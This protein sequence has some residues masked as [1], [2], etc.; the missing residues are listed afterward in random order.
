MS[1]TWVVLT[2]EHRL[3]AGLAIAA[4]R[5]G[6]VGLL[7]LGLSAPLDRRRAELDRLRRHAREGGAWGVRWNVWDAPGRMPEALQ[8][9]ADGKVPVL[10]LA[11]LSG[12]PARVAEAVRQARR[13]ADRVYVEAYDPDQAR[14]ARDARPDTVVLVGQEAGGRAGA[15][16]TF[17]FVQAVGERLGLPYLV[18][19]ATGPD[20]AAALRLGGAEGVVL[21]EETWLAREAPFDARERRRLEALDGTET[22]LLAEEGAAVRLFRH[23]DRDAV[24]AL[25]VAE[26]GGLEAVRAV[27]ARWRERPP[28]SGGPVPMGQGVAFAARLAKTAGTLGRILERYRAEV[29]HHLDRAPAQRAL[30]PDATLARVH[31][32]R[33]PVVQGPMTRVSDVPAFARAVAEHG[34]LPFFALAL[35]R[36][37]AVRRML[38]GARSQLGASPWGVGILGFVPPQLREEQL[39]VVRE[40]RPRFAIVAGGRPAQ[41]AAL[42]AEGI[43]TYLHVPSPGLL[44]AFLVEGARR[45]VLEGRECGGHVGP[46]SSFVLWQSA[47][48]RLCD[49]GVDLATVRVLFAGGIHDA[50]SAG[51]VQTLAAGLVERGV[52]IGV[53]LGTA[54]L[55]TPEAVATG[56]IS[57]AFQEEAIA[58]R[59]TTLLRSGLGH[60]S[61]CADTAFAEEFRS[62]RRSLLAAGRSA[63]DVRVDLEILNVGRLRVAS[64]GLRRRGRADAEA[65]DLASR[66]ERLEGELERVDSSEQR[67]EGMFMLGD[68]ATLRDGRQSMAALHDAVSRGAVEWTHRHA[69]PLAV[70]ARRRSGGERIAIVGMACCFPGAPDLASFWACV[71]RGADAVRDVPES[72]WS[73]SLFYDPDRRAP[74]RLYARRGAFLE[75][76][77]FDPLRYGIPPATVTHLEPVQLL[78]LETARRAL[79]DAGFDRHPFPRERTSVIFGSSG[80]H[81]LG[82]SYVFRTMVE[83]LL[84]R[85]SSLGDDARRRAVESVRAALPPWTEDVFPGVLPNLIAGRIANRLDLMGANYVVDA[86]CSSS[87][88]ALHAAVGQLRSR[89]ADVVVVGAA[90]GSNNAFTFM[91]FAKTQAL[92]PGDVPRPFDAGADGIVLGEGVGAVVLKRLEDAERD[93]DDV[94][95]VIRGIGTSSDG[96]N[97]SLT[98][99]HPAGQVLALRRA[100]EDAGVDPATVELIEA[101]ATGTAVGDAAEIE[102][103]QAVLGPGRPT[104]AIGSVKSQIGHAKTAAGLAGLVKTALALSH[105][106]LPPTLHV[107]RP[108]PRLLEAGSRVYANTERR[109]WI[110]DV[111]HP[112]RRAGVSA[113]GFGGTNFHVVLEAYEDA[114]CPDATRDLAPRDAEVVSIGRP[115]REALAEAVARIE[116]ETAGLPEGA[117]ARVAAAVHADE[118]ARDRDGPD[119]A[120]LGVVA[121]SLS[122]LRSA[123]ARARE[124]LAAGA[125]LDEARGTWLSDAPPA[126]AKEVAFLFPGQGAQRIGMLGDLVTTAGFDTSVFEEA[127]H[128]LRDLLP[129][130]LSAYVFPQ[131][132]WTKADRRRRREELEDTR[133]AQPALGAVELFALDVLATFGL[134]PAFTAGHSYGEYVAL[135]AAGAYG[136]RDLL[137][138]SALRGAAV[139]DVA[140]EGEGGMIAVAAGEDEVRAALAEEHLGLEIAN[141][142]APRQTIVAGPRAAVDEGLTRLAARGLA[143]RRVPV[144][145]AFHTALV[146]E[147]SKAILPEL[148]K[149]AMRPPAVPVHSNVTAK[150]Y[151]RDVV[152]MKELLGR[153]LS[154]PVRFV[155]QVRAMHDAGARVFVEAGPGGILSGFV[156]RILEGRPH[157]TLPLDLPGEP[158]GLVL[159]RLLA[160]AFAIGLEVDLAPLFTRRGF[161]SRGLSEVTR[162]IREAERVRPTDVLVE[163]GGVSPVAPRAGEAARSAAPGASPA[164]GPASAP[165][166]R[167][168]VPAPARTPRAGGRDG[169]S[170]DPPPMPEPDP[171]PAPPPS[172]TPAPIERPLGPEVRGARGDATLPLEVQRTIRDWIGLQR[173]QQ[174]V[175]ERLIELQTRLLDGTPSG[176]VPP[177]RPPAEAGAS[178]AEPAFLGVVPTPVL[179]PLEPLASPGS[180]EVGGG[181]ADPSAPGPGAARGNDVSSDTPAASDTAGGARAVTGEAAAGE[182]P[183]VETFHQELLREVSR[184]TGYPE[185][186]LLPDVPLEAGLG[187]DSIKLMEIFSALKRYHR[188][189][190][191]PDQD[192]EEVL[193]EFT[194]LKTIGA[195]VERYAHQREVVGADVPPSP[196]DDGTNARAA[197]AS[198]AP[199]APPSGAAPSGSATATTDT[200][201]AATVA[202]PPA[203]P[204]ERWVLESVEAALPPADLEPTT[205][206][207]APDAGVLVLGD[208]P[209]AYGAIG[210]GLRSAGVP[211]WQVLPGRGFERLDE[212]RFAVD[213]EDRAA[214]DRL[215]AVLADGGRRV[216]A[217]VNLLG[218]DPRVRDATDEAGAGARILRQLLTVGQAFGPDLR[219]SAEAGGAL[220]LNVTALDGRFGL[221]GRRPLAVAQAASVGF[222]KALAKE[223][224]GV[225]VKSIDVD[226]DADAEIVLTRLAAEAGATDDLVEVGL[227]RAGRWRLD[228]AAAGGHGNGSGAGNGTGN[229][230]GHG[231]GDG[232]PGGDAGALAALPLDAESVVLV[233]GG[234]RGI[235]AEVLK[236][237][238]AASGA[239]LVI[240]G[241]SPRPGPAAEPADLAG[242]RDGA[243]LRAAL[244]RRAAASGAPPRP[245]AIE[246]EARRVLVEREV[247]AN[248]AAL[249]AT[250]AAVEYHALDVRDDEAFGNLID[251]VYARHG[252]IDGVIHAA[253]VVEDRRIEDKTAAS[254]ARVFDT[255]V[256]PALVLARRLD[257]ERLRFLAFFSSV[258]G[259]FGNAGQADYSAANEVLNKLAADL[260][261]RWPARVVAINWGPW[262]G[263]MLSDGLRRVYRERGIGLIDPADGSEAFL[264][265][266]R[267]TTERSPEVVWAVGAPALAR[268]GTTP[269]RR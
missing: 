55:F 201:S 128:L 258:S 9:L 93:G 211:A 139:H 225:R 97:R 78:A 151:P 205:L 117:L 104:C 84:L 136:R 199:A 120:R 111:R 247:R 183:S 210:S 36:E 133:V 209:E 80:I 170:G 27:L 141:L 52:A 83:Q 219:A 2:P 235:T 182:A 18:R 86:A 232:H 69:V 66:A 179:A 17:L 268:G 161:G 64:K 82:I 105:R 67:R 98:A 221:G 144:S 92:T 241:R 72:R 260:D 263:G 180:P 31:G 254:C 65:D 181:G 246:T 193:A 176:S 76:I 96:R 190:A 43:E 138:V 266:I 248:L 189:F 123:L 148:E 59:R 116:G 24:A 129:V 218:L 106:T 184:R 202:S 51:M 73:P 41:A 44:E 195:I 12:D 163:P 143:A 200:P 109:P 224:P 236:R 6:A 22:V 233:T 191:D 252:R 237:L 231:D 137:V 249:E 216:G 101:H 130:P 40:I 1:T 264:D 242:A 108:N 198:V 175:F 5:A 121:S 162:E 75:P 54:Y 14:A 124:A 11:G 146:T 147:A 255:K 125:G 155:E 47:I 7:D 267:R 206:G 140:A 207:L 94:Y 222:F 107:E 23:E 132:A 63:E 173:E 35:L 223:W 49:A 158:G 243:A 122:D 261:R 194:R 220:L 168:V 79:E 81:D 172:P 212:R 152:A 204:V 87:L 192:E 228:L 56:A 164:D 88:A 71:L 32:T 119:A 4:A 30:A 50:A 15:L 134:R 91:G 127:D 135:H 265:E 29:R 37:D 253:G 58:C 145:A 167:A 115:T 196:A 113:F 240:V 250:G 3:D 234:A 34:A 203:R 149:V 169:E 215:R 21:S 45:F 61:R 156:R 100:Y 99:P 118:R 185:D 257:P 197:R 153:H 60:A 262:D 165:K 16:S 166:A 171:S 57:P 188:Y 112:A 178:G 70:G 160:R 187:I 229:G 114:F 208:G 48:D 90:D 269:G 85:T 19:G 186:L 154:H 226:P 110:R 227:D 244:A 157:V 46:R 214:V 217:L 177:V 259:R 42:E 103:L 150:P 26:P 102:S 95:A 131:P 13:L 8:G 33:Y 62:R 245:E 25:E 89:V 174:R 251:D 238:A 39:R 239:L 53:L 213:L 68:V 38:E 256:R 10:L 20:V 28:E 126:R 159:A 74:D 142:N 230:N 77:R